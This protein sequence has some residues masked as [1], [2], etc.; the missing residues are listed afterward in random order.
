MPATPFKTPFPLPDGLAEKPQ[1]QIY[2]DFQEVEK[3]LGPLGQPKPSGGLLRDMTTGAFTFNSSVTFGATTFS[4]TLTTTGN[5]LELY[6]PAST[7][8]I[9]FHH[10]ANSAGD[11]GA[12]YNMRII[13]DA[14][15]QLS[16][17]G[18]KLAMGSGS[19]FI[20]SSS[21]IAVRIQQAGVSG[22]PTVEF[23]ESD[24][25]T[26]SGQVTGRAGGVGLV[27]NA[28]TGITEVN[29]GELLVS[30]G[31][32]V[33][34]AGAAT[35]CHVEGSGAGYQFDERDNSA[36]TWVWYGTGNQ[37]R[38]WNNNGDMVF[39]ERASGTL[40]SLGYLVCYQGAAAQGFFGQW[41]GTG[42]YTSIDSQ[43]DNN[44]NGASYK[45]LFGNNSDSSMYLSYGNV[46]ATGV[47]AFR[48]ANNGATVLTVGSFNS[49]NPL[50]NNICM[51]VPAI[52]G[53]TM[54]LNTTSTQVGYSTSSGRH[55]H[56]V[57]ALR[58]TPEKD[59]G[60]DNPVFKMRPVRFNWKHRDVAAGDTEGIVNGDEINARYPNGVVGLITEE[61]HE[62]APDLVLWKEE[63]LEWHWGEGDLLPEHDADGNP[64]L[65]KPAE[66]AEMMHFDHDRLL[67][68]IIDAVQHLKEE[69]DESKRSKT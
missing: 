10:A 65:H 69:I 26:V 48:L 17:F 50:S 11:G 3:F 67:G 36:N 32:F 27:L 41:P 20:S 39:V 23:L 35:N 54:M 49:T 37:A 25:A 63:R 51:G 43:V 28:A 62:V 44:R 57:R 22:N 5:G 30:N 61:V 18:G 16:V 68:Y 29:N 15:G 55:K 9:D 7:P 60:A 33:V 24:G 45:M 8:F 58:D 52:A 21:G 42:G 64:I 12:D 59:S 34:S 40:R 14:S 53:N 6:Q 2:T 46:S 13:N 56:N 47:V 38:L 1:K 4:G 31:Q 66:P 19:Q